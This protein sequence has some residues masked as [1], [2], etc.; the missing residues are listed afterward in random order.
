MMNIIGPYA[1]APVFVVACNISCLFKG[2]IQYLILSKAK[3]EGNCTICTFHQ[4]SLSSLFSIFSGSSDLAR[5]RFLC[6]NDFSHSS[7]K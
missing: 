3:Q 4:P 5:K 6:V 2:R 1:N 7:L